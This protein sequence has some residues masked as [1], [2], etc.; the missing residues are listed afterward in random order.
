MIKKSEKSKDTPRVIAPP[1]LIYGGA[2]L[3]GYLFHLIFPIQVFPSWSSPIMGWPLIFLSGVLVIPGIWALK[4]AGTHV[5]PYKPTTALV[6][7]GPFRVT[8]NPLYLSLSLLYTGGS[9]LLNM[10]STLLLLP[11][12]LAIMH[13]GVIAREERYLEKKFGEEY[14][15]YKTRVRRWI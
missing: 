9:I 15:K 1:P 4:K 6:V 10:L 11:I 2:F 12:I 5:D 14:L 3:S 8:R 13:F 7:N